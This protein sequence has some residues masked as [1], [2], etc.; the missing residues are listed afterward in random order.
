MGC[1]EARRPGRP[2]GA[3]VAMATGGGGPAPAGGGAGGGTVR[4]LGEG[5]EGARGSRG[6]WAR[7]QRM[8]SSSWPPSSCCSFG[9]SGSTNS[10]EE[11]RLTRGPG[12]LSGFG[13]QSLCISLKQI[14]YVHPPSPSLSFLACDTAEMDQEDLP[15]HISAHYIFCDSGD[16]AG[17]IQGWV[18]SPPLPLEARSQ[19]RDAHYAGMSELEELAVSEPSVCIIQ[20]GQQ[21]PR[22][23]RRPVQ[24]HTA[25]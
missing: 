6:R 22:E 10:L 2:A 17:R 18:I 4:G 7:P 21:L 19:H 13:S 16:R 11:H 12:S 5:P 9:D 1:A 25:S 23:G 8:S 14:N 3:R 20:N 15:G 24:G